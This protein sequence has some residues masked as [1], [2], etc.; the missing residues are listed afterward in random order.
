MDQQQTIIFIGSQ[1]SG[2]GTQAQRLRELMEKEGGGTPTFLFSMGEEF[3]K[4]AKE[5]GVTEGMVREYLERGELLPTFLPIWMWTRLFIQNVKG[6]E[7]IIF[8]GSPRTQ[9]EAEIL[10]SAFSFFDRRSVTVL[11][12]NVSR[13]E[14]VKR[15][16]SRGREDDTEE[17]IET[18]IA[19]YEENV[20]AALDFFAGLPRYRFVDINGEQTADAVFDEIVTKLKSV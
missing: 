3:R 1:G 14:I 11:R 2:K 13:E 6:N 12:L 18:R 17:V 4:F 15:L 10:E 8:D 7:H 19:W 5:E 20:G 16:M 9:F